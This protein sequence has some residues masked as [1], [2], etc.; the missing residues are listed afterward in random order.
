MTQT[1]EVTSM[2]ELSH[3]EPAHPGC[4]LLCGQE[5]WMLLGYRSAN[6]FSQAAR[7]GTTPVPVFRIAGR[8]GQHALRADVEAWLAKLPE[9]AGRAE[10]ARPPQVGRMN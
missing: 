3:I 2:T 7:R 1:T 5:L 9:L 6:A 8:R 4:P 10:F